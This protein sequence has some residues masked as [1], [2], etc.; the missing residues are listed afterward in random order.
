MNNRSWIT[1]A[2]QQYE[3]DTADVPERL[4]DVYPPYKNN[5]PSANRQAQDH[6]NATTKKPANVEDR[7]DTRI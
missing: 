6:Q 4:L 7:S 1:E 2:I 3:Q 5:A